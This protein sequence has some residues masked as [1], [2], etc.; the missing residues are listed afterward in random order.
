VVQRERKGEKK[1]KRNK[2][3]RNESRELARGKAIDWVKGR[4]GK[5]KRGVHEWGWCI[6][7]MGSGEG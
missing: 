3:R 4:D 2:R 5:A 6:F 7:G 1:K